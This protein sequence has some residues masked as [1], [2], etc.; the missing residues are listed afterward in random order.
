MAKITIEL[1]KITNIKSGTAVKGK[2][3][4]N[5]KA[6]NNLKIP[7]TGPGSKSGGSITK[8]EQPIQPKG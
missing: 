2:K 6:G 4:E 8:I 1:D 5:L 3:P 7:D